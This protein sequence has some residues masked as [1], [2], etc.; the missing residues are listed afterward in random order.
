LHLCL[1]LFNH[2]VHIRYNVI[3]LSHCSK[4]LVTTYKLLVNGIDDLHAPIFQCAKLFGSD[5]MFPHQCIHRRS[6]YKRMREFP[7]ASNASLQFNQSVSQ[8]MADKLTRRLSQSPFESLPSVLAESGA[9]RRISAHL[10]SF[11][12]DFSKWAKV[13]E[14]NLPRYALQDLHVSDMTPIHS[15]RSRFPL[16]KEYHFYQRSAKPISYKQ[17]SPERR[18]KVRNSKTYAM[19]V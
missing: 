10:L 9:I 18:K 16:Q 17:A 12:K 8:F 4:S 3:H 14:C 13:H 11:M 15:H 19:F 5:W 1:H 7:G 6:H 2:A